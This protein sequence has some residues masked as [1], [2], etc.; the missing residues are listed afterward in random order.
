MSDSHPHRSR[1]QLALPQNNTPEAWGC[2]LVSGL[3]GLLAIVLG[4]TF[5]GIVWYRLS[6]TEAFGRFVTPPPI[7]LNV[8]DLAAFIS[9][10]ITATLVIASVVAMREAFLRRSQR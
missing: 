7:P 3:L 2:V 5:L 6:W 1:I 9:F 4:A 10:C 8:L